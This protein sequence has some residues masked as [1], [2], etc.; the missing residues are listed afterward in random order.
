MAKIVICEPDARCRALLSYILE[1][2][3]HRVLEADDYDAL[4]AL[5]AADPPDL[6]ILGVHGE[7]RLPS[8]QRSDWRP[9]LPDLPVLLLFGGSSELMEEYLAA[10]DGPKTLNVLHQPLEPYPLLAMVKSMVTA[11]E[12]WRRGGQHTV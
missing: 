7:E 9:A 11:P 6:L 1:G 2:I 4:P 10:W 3:H 12:T 5:I 8:S